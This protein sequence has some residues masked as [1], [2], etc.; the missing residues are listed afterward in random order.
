MFKD[1]EK[2][3]SSHYIALGKLQGTLDTYNSQLV[4]IDAEMRTVR[5]QIELLDKVRIFLQKLGEVARE[6]AK[7]RIEEV[8]TYALQYVFGPHFSFRI[9]LRGTIVR[10][11]ADFFVVTKYGDREIINSPEGSRGGG[12][13]DIVSTALRFAMLEL[14]EPEIE[15]SL[16]LDEPFKHVSEEYREAAR[17]LL[18]YMVTA[19]SRQ[20]VIIT[21]DP[22][23][24]AAAQKVIGIRLSEN[25]ISEVY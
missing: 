20:V 6:E 15:G 8:V 25:G 23:L 24:A 17:N 21:H 12:I 4:I 11:E 16:L 13:S 19:S 22:K 5:N 14:E 10:P 1:I 7:R 3:L 18:L 2:D 9:I